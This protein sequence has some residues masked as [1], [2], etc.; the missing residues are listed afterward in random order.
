MRGHDPTDLTGHDL[1]AD[2]LAVWVEK[3]PVP[4]QVKF[5]TNDGE[6][7]TLEGPVKYQ[8]GDALLTGETS[9]QW[10]VRRSKFDAWYEPE[11]GVV[12]G[13]DGTYRKRPMVVRARR[14]E[15]EFGVRVG[16]ADDLIQGEPGD[17]L[18]MYGP[19]DYGVVRAAQFLGSYRVIRH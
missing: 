7:L 3:L 2:P 5:A 14:M 12:A 6:L 15:Q 11:A 1:Q 8:Q 13:Q 18:L 9:D 10:P 17:W 4:V 16:H 19:G